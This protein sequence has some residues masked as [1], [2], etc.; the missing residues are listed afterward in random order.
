MVSLKTL[1]F[2]VSI[3]NSFIIYMTINKWGGNESS[4]G[5][6]SLT[7]CPLGCPPGPQSKKKI[8]TIKQF[9]INPH[10]VLGYKSPTN[11]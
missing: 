5:L 7:H 9:V 1:R 2:L 10:V 8:S 4:P 6:G 3:A 11:L